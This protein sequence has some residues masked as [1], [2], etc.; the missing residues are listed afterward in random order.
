MSAGCQA[1]QPLDPPVMGLRFA[2]CYA[3]TV[4]RFLWICD[5]MHVKLAAVC[6]AHR[7]VPGAWGCSVC[8][9]NGHECPME[10]RQVPL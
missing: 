1:K 8:W 3:P 7:P 9:S 5:C 4:A 2:I 10:F 6:E